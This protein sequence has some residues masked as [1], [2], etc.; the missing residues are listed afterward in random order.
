MRMSFEFWTQECT[1][2]IVFRFI[3]FW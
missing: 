1:A 2:N 3:W